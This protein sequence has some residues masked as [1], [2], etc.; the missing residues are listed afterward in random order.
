MNSAFAKALFSTAGG[1]NYMKLIIGLGNPGKKYANTRH[2]T[3]FQCLDILR[4]KMAFPEWKFEKK[5]N[6]EISAGDFEGTKCFLVKPQ[7]Y[8][9][10]SGKPAAALAQFYGI[11]QTD[12]W[13]IY[14]DIDLPLGGLR[15]RQEGSAGSHN[16]MKSVIKNLGFQN[17]PR[18]R[19]GIESRETSASKQ[20]D[21]SSFVL[22]A[23]SKEEQSVAKQAIEKAAETLLMALKS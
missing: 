10:E 19:I 3:G 12:L 20:Q 16:G 13:V 9:N 6:A 7:T 1:K 2:N 17:F 22:H 5:F 21:I 4:K 15:V 18:I 8:M 23:F 11:A 14:D